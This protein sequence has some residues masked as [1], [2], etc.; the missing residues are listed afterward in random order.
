MFVVC[1]RCIYELTFF[2]ICQLVVKM[3][4]FQKQMDFVVVF[5]S[6]YLTLTFLKYFL[7][8]SYKTV[9]HLGRFCQ[10][11]GESVTGQLHRFLCQLTWLFIGN[12]PNSGYD[13]EFDSNVDKLNSYI[14]RTVPTSHLDTFDDVHFAQHGRVYLKLFEIV[15]SMKHRSRSA[16]IDGDKRRLESQRESLESVMGNYRL[17][18]PSQIVHAT[19]EVSKLKSLF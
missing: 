1:I 5:G 9:Q 16:I 19:A 7:P 11:M 10:R 14:A 6:M 8:F 12:P 2:L 18:S 15:R 17:L 3:H 4:A 13:A